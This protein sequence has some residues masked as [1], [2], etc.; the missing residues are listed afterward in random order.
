LLVSV[1]HYA[2]LAV[3]HQRALDDLRRHSELAQRLF[4]SRFPPRVRENLLREAANG[5][6]LL[7]TRQSHITVLTSDIRGFTQLTAQLGAQRARD[8]LDE[9]FPPL[10]EAVHAHQGTVERLVGDGVF[11]VFGS[12]EPD[13]QQQE[14]AVRAALAMQAA[15]ATIMKARAARKTGTCEI[16]IGIDCGEALHG[17]I[18][19]AERLD[20]HVVGQPVNLASRYCSAAG[21]GEILI[22]EQVHAR[23][24]NKFKFERIEISTK[25]KETLCAYRIKAE[26]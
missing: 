11:A 25:E 6:L 24:F 26:N 17:F 8:L 15:T 23:V 2:A 1:A 5:S 7:G 14:H 12:P 16:G 19:N 10:I 4:T 18:G 21:K 3:A 13:D 22:S 20:Y 9:Y